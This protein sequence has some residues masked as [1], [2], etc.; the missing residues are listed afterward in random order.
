M[1]V[2]TTSKTT[3]SRMLAVLSYTTVTG[4]YVSTVLASLRQMCRHVF[5]ARDKSQS[6]FPFRLTSSVV[7]PAHPAQINTF[8]PNKGDSSVDMDD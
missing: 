8:P 2:S 5:C 4:G 3:T 7:H 1:M 6:L